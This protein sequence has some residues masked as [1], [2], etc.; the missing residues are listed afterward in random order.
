MVKLYSRPLVKELVTQAYNQIKHLNVENETFSYVH[1]LARLLDLAY[2]THQ[3]HASVLAFP[4][5]GAQ[6]VKKRI[7]ALGYEIGSSNIEESSHLEY[8][9][10]VDVLRQM[11]H[12]LEKEHRFYLEWTTFPTVKWIVGFKV[13]ERVRNDDSDFAGSDSHSFGLS[14]D[15][16]VHI[17]NESHGYHQPHLKMEALTGFRT[18]GFLIDLHKGC[19]QLVAEGRIISP[20]FGIGA[21]MFSQEEQERQR[22][23]ILRNQLIPMFSVKDSSDNEERPLVK[24]NF[25]DKPFIFTANAQP[26]NAITQPIPT[27]GML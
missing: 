14:S 21:A 27:K 7:A 23:L 2:P 17:D 10:V 20:A 8:K 26:M 1:L 6:I 18:C 16:Y 11:C 13:A 9:I 25:G 4:L 22:D 12:K 19:I 24:I 3:L 15:G 5:Y